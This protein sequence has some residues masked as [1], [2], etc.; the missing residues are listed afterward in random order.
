[1]VVG[2]ERFDFLEGEAEVICKV[3]RRP[4]AGQDVVSLAGQRLERN[5]RLVCE[6]GVVVGGD[7]REVAALA[8]VDAEGGVVVAAK[9]AGGHADVLL[10]REGEPDVATESVAVRVVAGGRRQS[11][12]EAGR[13][14]QR[15]NTYRV[16]EVVVRRRD[17]PG[18]TEVQLAA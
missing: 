17:D 2:R 8:G 6:E 15:R 7:R 10:R 3:W 4:P 16:V 9:G 5:I 14:V 12:I 18:N 1:I 13:K 11:D